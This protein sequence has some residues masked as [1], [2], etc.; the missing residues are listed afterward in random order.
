MANSTTVLNIPELIEMILVHV[1]AKDLLLQQRVSHMWQTVIEDST[2]L[3]QKLFFKP[4]LATED[5]L[6]SDIF[7]WNPY[8]S[9]RSWPESENRIRISHQPL[10]TKSG[11]IPSWKRMFVTNP[12]AR[13]GFMQRGFRMVHL[14]RSYPW[15]KM[16]D[17]ADF[18]W[19][20]RQGEDLSV[21]VHARL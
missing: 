3:Q 11:P 9:T 13:N 17:I 16:S 20:E 8:L 14:P 21:I 2:S 5:E 12:T 10:T 15:V 7:E 4:R 6:N 18:Q 1:P 19:D